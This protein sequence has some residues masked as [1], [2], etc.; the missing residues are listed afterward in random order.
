[1]KKTLCFILAAAMLLALAGCGAA[2]ETADTAATP[3][4]AVPPTPMPTAAQTDVDGS[5]ANVVEVSTVDELLAAIS[6]NTKIILAEGNYDLS[7]ASDYGAAATGA[8]YRWEEVFD[9]ETEGYT[10]TAF[11]LIVAGVNNLAL[12]AENGARVT[13]SAVPRYANVLRFEASSDLLLHGI[14][15]GHTEEPGVCAG[16]VV[17]LENVNGARISACSLYGCGTVG[18]QAYTC[19]NVYISDSSIFDC[20]DSAVVSSRCTDV[21]VE[22]CDVFDCGLSGFAA[23]FSA[24]TTT[25]FA[26][27]NTD[28]RNCT[29]AALFG[30][31]STHGAALLGCGVNGSTAFDR[32]LFEITGESVTVD[33]CR[34]DRSL[35]FPLLYSE[36]A[37]GTAVT[38]AGE[39]LTQDILF[40]MERAEVDYT[41]PE[42]ASAPEVDL[43]VTVNADGIREV[44]VSTVDEFLAAIAPDT[45]IYL[46]AELYDLSTATVYG[47]AGGEWYGWVENFDGPG[48]VI[49]GVENLGIMSAEGVSATISAVPRYAD[50]LTFSGCT[51]IE[52]NNVTLGHTEEPGECSGGVLNFSQCGNVAID[53]SRLFGCGTVGITAYNS[54]AIAINDTEIYDCTYSAA[55]FYT[56]NDVVFS[57]CNI[58]HCGTPELVVTDSSVT[59][60]GEALKS[61]DYTFEG[62]KLVE[63]VYPDMH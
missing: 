38:A 37:D 22:R 47:G 63:Y 41:L 1:M 16:G 34:F 53:Q 42:T 26:V 18:V 58:H 44:H 43:D 4:S 29:G 15:V 61:L 17:L 31:T 25:G 57:N 23:I 45:T 30:A 13:I 24:D 7:S 59:Y 8:R 52:I 21:R 3:V 39:E 12:V 46:D 6:D 35:Y 33:K 40:A 50:V 56:C 14:T 19:R 27:V 49:Y 60:D 36:F 51:Y 48:L 9:L 54:S 55:I 10:G 62:G 20:S 2:G 11:E 5:W 28:I 32:A